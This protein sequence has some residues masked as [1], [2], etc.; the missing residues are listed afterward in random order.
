MFILIFIFYFCGVYISKFIKEN[1]DNPKAREEVETVAEQSW[2]Y[3][4]SGGGESA[5]SP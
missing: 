4:C 1:K 3:L 5:P 2:D